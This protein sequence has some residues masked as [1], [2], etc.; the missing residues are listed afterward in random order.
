[1]CKISFRV[2][3][4][5]CLGNT[6]WTVVS[7]NWR[8]CVKTGFPNVSLKYLWPIMA[9]H[10]FPHSNCTKPDFPSP[11][12]SAGPSIISLQAT[13]QGPASWAADLPLLMSSSGIILSYPNHF[14]WGDNRRISHIFGIIT[15]IFGIATYITIHEGNRV[16]NQDKIVR[17]TQ[18]FENCSTRN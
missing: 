5:D 3:S 9:Y 6:L 7:K 15:Y 11:I 12:L 14:F 4:F 2:R 13:N 17:M 1:M 8:L 10:H 18:G 16:L